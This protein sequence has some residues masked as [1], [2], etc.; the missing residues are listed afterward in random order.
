[1]ER[2]FSF[3]LKVLQ[4]QLANTAPGFVLRRLSA[5]P[6]Q[7]TKSIKFMVARARCVMYYVVQTKIR[8]DVAWKQHGNYRTMVRLIT[9]NFLMTYTV[10]TSWVC[11]AY[12][13]IFCSDGMLFNTSYLAN[14]THAS[15]TYY[16]Y[17]HIHIK[18]GYT[19]PYVPAV[20]SSISSETWWMTVAVGKMSITSTS[21]GK[22]YKCDRTCEN[23]QQC[24]ILS[25]STC[26]FTTF[27]IGNINGCIFVL[28]SSLMVEIVDAHT[29]QTC[30]SHIMDAKYSKISLLM[31]YE[32]C[33]IFPDPITNML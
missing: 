31:E 7:T 33:W 26:K 22:P 23:P 27:N 9:V 3:R 20:Y 25:I 15:N 8:P 16:T 24:S 19:I 29:S 5:F 4:L 12:A 17:I 28:C 30:N 32:K 18:C 13:I 6:Q 1:M 14:V 10:H 21:V 2:P 11:V